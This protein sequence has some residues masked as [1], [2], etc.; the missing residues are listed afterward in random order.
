MKIKLL[1]KIALA[2]LVGV[3]ISTAQAAQ[4]L[5]PF[6]LASNDAGTIADKVAGTKSALSENGFEIAGEYTPYKGAHVIVVTNGELKKA[7]ASQE[8]G[9]YVAAQRISLTEMSGKVQVSYTNPIYMSYAYRVNNKLPQT[10]ASLKKALGHVQDF[11]PAEGIE[12]DD[13]NDYHYTF[14][15]EYFDEPLELNSKGSHDEM[16]SVIQKNLSAKTSGAS[17]VYKIE[18]P[19]TSQTLF[20]VAMKAPNEGKKYMDEGFIMSEI[21]F[22]PLRSTAHLPYEILE[23]GKEA[24]ALHARFR[25][26]INF[27]DLAMMGDNSFMNI[28]AS[29]D[30]IRD[31]LSAVAGGEVED[32]DF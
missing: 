20:G 21:D 6:A 4:A 22:K 3:V 31:V 8:R 11:G 25:I 27:P 13:L 16:V 10:T 2:M 15:M 26:A 1:T 14:G 32:E 19:G 7:A 29:P 12:S 5:L 30:A 23:N 24:E 28:M 18:I 9:G 17:Q